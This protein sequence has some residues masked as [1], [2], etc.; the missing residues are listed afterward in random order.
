MSLQNVLLLYIY[1]VFIEEMWIQSNISRT[2]S[3]TIQLLQKLKLSVGLRLIY[4]VA[5]VLHTPII[6]KDLQFKQKAARK[7]V[8]KNKLL[9]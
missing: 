2:R 6:P 4:Y 1:S 7:Q 9:L 5:F 8:M 3:V